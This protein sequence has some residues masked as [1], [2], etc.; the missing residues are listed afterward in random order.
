MG[1]SDAGPPGVTYLAIVAGRGGVYMG[2][3]QE[4][5]GRF[6][7]RSS[8]RHPAA[9][10]VQHFPK[11]MTRISSACSLVESDS[12]SSELSTTYN[13]LKLRSASCRSASVSS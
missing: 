4:D 6:L 11:G 13:V 3:M 7:R 5:R 8:Q 10:V 12:D 2:S 9:S 1:G